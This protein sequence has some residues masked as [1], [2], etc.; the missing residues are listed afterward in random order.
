MSEITL[1]TKLRYLLAFSTSVQEQ[2]RRYIALGVEI[3]TLSSELSR[4]VA[5]ADEE[6]E[7][8]TGAAGEKEQSR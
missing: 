7:R 5:L 3:E 4:I 2:I 6:P 8:F 1:A